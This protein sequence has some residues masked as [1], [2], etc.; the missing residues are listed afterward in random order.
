MLRLQHKNLLYKSTKRR[1]LADTGAEVILTFGKREGLFV[2]EGKNEWI[3][4][5]RERKENTFS[6]E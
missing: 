3:V 6:T 4:F 1:Q 5:Q 2:H